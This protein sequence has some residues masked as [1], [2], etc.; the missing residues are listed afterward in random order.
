M[1]NHHKICYLA[2]PSTK[3]GGG[4]SGQAVVVLYEA[5][6]SKNVLGSTV[7]LNTDDTTPASESAVATNVVKV[8]S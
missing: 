7:S 6:P 5:G 4:G 3:K 2:L 1:W 8:E